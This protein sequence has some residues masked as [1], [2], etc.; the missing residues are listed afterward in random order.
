MMRCSN[1]EQIRSQHSRTYGSDNT[2]C[3]PV[4]SVGKPC[5]ILGVTYYSPAAEA[6]VRYWKALDA[7]GRAGTHLL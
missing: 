4:L 7:S 1:R 2:C 6:D 5:S 3:H